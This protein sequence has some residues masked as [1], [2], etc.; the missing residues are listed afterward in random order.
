MSYEDMKWQWEYRMYLTK[1]KKASYKENTLYDPSYTPFWQNY[2][3]SKLFTVI[4]F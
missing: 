1:L 4:V 3:I 2:Y